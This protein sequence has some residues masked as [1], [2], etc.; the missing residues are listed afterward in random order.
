MYKTDEAS[1]S[2]P[3]RLSAGN[4]RRTYRVNSAPTGVLKKFFSRFFDVSVP[5][6]LLMSYLNAT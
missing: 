2:V 6:V 1:R 4:G 3:R 5:A